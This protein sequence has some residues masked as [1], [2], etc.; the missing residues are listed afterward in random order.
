[1]TQDRSIRILFLTIVLLLGGTLPGWGVD[2]FGGG[3]EVNVPAQG[4]TELDLKNEVCVYRGYKGTPVEVLVEEPPMRLTAEK[5]IYQQGEELLTAEEGA[6]LETE[7]M[8]ATG[9]KMAITPELLRLPVGGEITSL[10]PAAWRLMSNGEISYQLTADTFQGTGGFTLWGP[11]WT[12]QGERFAGDLQE[13]TVTAGGK[14]QF[15]SGKTWGEAGTISYQQEEEKLILTESPLICWEEGFLQG[16]AE[17]I[18]IYDLASG[19]A[20]V[21]GP[22]KTRFYQD[23]GVHPSGD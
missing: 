7:Q 3:I 11:E 8:I 14:L 15:R 2:E 21:E 4:I 22:T 9:T 19:E 1:M 13:G 23:R 12:L 20:K 16:E 18:I 10:T 5:V 17:T 6:T